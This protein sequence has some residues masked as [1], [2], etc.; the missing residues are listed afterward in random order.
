MQNMKNII[1]DWF[2]SLQLYWKNTLVVSKKSTIPTIKVF[3]YRNCDL[4]EVFWK[5]NESTFSLQLKIYLCRGAYLSAMFYQFINMVCKWP[6]FWPSFGFALALLH[7]T[8]SL[9]ITFYFISLLI[10]VSYVVWSFDKCS[11]K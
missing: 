10:E 7:W 2:L 1:A 8:K 4:N 6:F 5:Q 3:L 9:E 11:Q